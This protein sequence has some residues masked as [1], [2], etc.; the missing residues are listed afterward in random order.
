[1]SN[2]TLSIK[3]TYFDQIKSGKK[4]F[5]EREIRPNN[6]ARYCEVDDEGFVLENED[7]EP[8]TRHYDTITFLTGAYKGTR[9][10]MIVE[11]KESY[12]IILYDEETKEEVTYDHNGETYTAA[13]I[14]YE[15]GKVIS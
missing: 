14:R 8:I 9:E 2:L 12:T 4:T 7:N 15:L 6:I 3:Q 5:E 13:L 1:M 10:K 11:V